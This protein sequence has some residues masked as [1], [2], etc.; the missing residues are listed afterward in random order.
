MAGERTRRCAP[1]RTVSRTSRGGPPKTMA[2]T[3]TFVSRTSRM[4]LRRSVRPA[5]PTDGGH[6]RRHVALLQ[7]QPLRLAPAKSKDR[8]PPFLAGDVLP[9]GFA[10]QLRTGAGLAP[11]RPVYPVEKRLGKSD[12]H[13]DG[14]HRVLLSSTLSLYK[15]CI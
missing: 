7:A 12:V 1:V 13:G 4:S 14:L 9:A 10:H 6:G 3:R 8:L 11:R 5:R 15:V 2:E